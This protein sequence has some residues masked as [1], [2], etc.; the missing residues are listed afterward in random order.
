[1][2]DEDSELIN[3]L[4]DNVPNLIALINNQNLN[5]FIKEIISYSF[6]ANKYF[7]DSEPWSVKKKTLKEW[8][9]YYLLYVNK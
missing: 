6:D 4:K 7:N 5:D 3:K 8:K 9:T 2:S 1:M